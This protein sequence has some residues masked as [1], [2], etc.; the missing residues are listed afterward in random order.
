MRKYILTTCLFVLSLVCLHA[1]QPQRPSTSDI[2]QSIQKLNF[3]GSV[4]YVAAHPDD[5][6][7]RLI[8]H[9]QSC[10]S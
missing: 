10:K 4:L 9:V 3:L 1:Q 6:N 8:I 5:E 2:Y 7:T